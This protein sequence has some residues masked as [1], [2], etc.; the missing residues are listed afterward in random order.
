M[1]IDVNV[2][3][4][5]PRDIPELIRLYNGVNEINDYPGVIFNH[6]YFRHFIGSREKIILVAESGSSVIGAL[7][8]EFL[9]YAKYTYLNHAVI[10]KK[11]MNN[12]IGNLLFREIE[13]KTRK[14]GYKLIIG[15]AYDWN[16]RI[17]KFLE[18]HG[19]AESGKTIFYIK[20]L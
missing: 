17:Q 20:K 18:H 11:N 19:Y 12:G 9:S 15:E 6:S 3:A 7:S 5:K 14:K 2:R 1:G 16:K 13:S 8:A 10:S 4:A